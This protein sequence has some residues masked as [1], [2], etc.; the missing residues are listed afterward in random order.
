[1]Y[2]K[3]TKRI[4][5]TFAAMCAAVL[6]LACS[7]DSDTVL[8]SQQ[9]A[10][11]TYLT[12]S[13]QPKLIE[14]YDIPTSSEE[15]PQFYTHWALNI[16]RYISTYYDEGREEKAIIEKG[17]TFDIKYTAYIF[18]SGKPSADSIYA[19]NDADIIESLKSN[20]L[21]TEYEWTT[22]P[23]TITLGRSEL[24]GGL[25]TALEGCREGDKVEVYLTYEAAYGKQYIG[26]VPSKSAVMWDIEILDVK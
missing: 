12:G 26:F 15:E 5:T 13:H 1:M 3:A 23:Y 10:I 17:T 8:T 24:V 2:M 21:N 19:T 6:M 7:N 16:F 25:N 11:K 20:G 4:Y 18:K 9:N 22:E 14:E